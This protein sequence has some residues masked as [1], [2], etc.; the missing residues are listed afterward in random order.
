MSNLNLEPKHKLVYDI[1]SYPNY[2]AI[3]M[4]MV[5]GPA[6]GHKAYYEISHRRDDRQALNQAMQ[7]MAGNVWMIGFNNLAFD[8]PLLNQIM[9]DINLPLDDFLDRQWEATQTL[10]KEQWPP[11]IPYDHYI[12]IDLYKIWHFDNKARRTS[13]K[14]LEF[15]MNMPNIIDLPIE[16][17]TVVNEQQMD[18]LAH[19][20]M[21]SDIPSTVRFYEHSIDKIKQR[22]QFTA[23]YGDDFM[24]LNDT[25]VGKRFF[26]NILRKK[27][28][29]L[30][31]DG[32]PVQTYYDELVFSD[33]IFSWF[34]FK[35]PEFKSIYRFLREM[36]SYK[37]K[38]IFK[39]YPVDQLGKLANY[40][41]EDN[42]VKREIKRLG[43]VFPRRIKS[44]HV[45]RNGLTFVL[46]TGGIHASV[47]NRVYTDAGG[48]V[49]D[50][51]DVT[52]FYPSNI[53]LNHIA[54]AHIGEWF[55]RIYI[56]LKMERLKYAKGTTENAI[57]KLALNGVFGDLGNQH[58]PLYDLIAMISVTLNGQLALLMLAEELQDIGVELIQCNTDG[59]TLYY[60][61]SMR[62]QVD[63]ICFRWEVG[64]G[65][66]L[67][68]AIYSR[69][70]VNN[71]NNYI[72]E[73][74]ESGKLKLKGAYAYDFEESGEWHK[75]FSARIIQIAAV[76]RMIHG[77]PVEQTIRECEDD[78]M[79]MIR[80]RVRGKSRIVWGDEPQQKTVRFYMDNAGKPIKKIMPPL[81]EGGEPRE[82]VLQPTNGLPV[83]VV[84]GDNRIIDRNSVNLNWYSEQATKLVIDDE[85]IRS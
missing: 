6:K 19:Y 73:Y 16:P 75:D 49:I 65:F 17:G 78:F 8:W 46:G 7:K 58:S 66:D 56:D 21:E 74:K 70:F 62:S 60:H 5:E 83:T 24:N 81:K 26:M 68:Q 84:N 53:I 43:K 38:E 3:G 54:P 76:E 48:Y 59:M 63:D 55:W 72:A 27:G 28:V 11:R 20:L 50:D 77:T 64:T 25:A 36:K 45:R 47:S 39:D 30:Y 13:L 22:A 14:D 34:R 18:Q 85:R 32:G 44:L 10:I 23:K 67:E 12:Q 61:E 41:D 80:G 57:L 35:S 37:T 31:E 15:N 2:C 51:R 69:M 52:S 79:F 29:K 42:Y 40:L 1:E 9:V 33:A 82:Q 4:E 71:V